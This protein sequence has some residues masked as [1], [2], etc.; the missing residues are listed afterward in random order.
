MSW[1]HTGSSTPL[2]HGEL[3]TRSTFANVPRGSCTKYDPDQ[4]EILD[5]QVEKV[6]ETADQILLRLS[7]I[8]SD[9]C[10]PAAPRI[11]AKTSYRGKSGNHAFQ[12][13]GVDYAGPLKYRKKSGKDG[14]AYIVLCTCS[15]TRVLYLELTSTMETRIPSNFETIN[16]K[17]WETRKNYSDN[18]RTFVGAARWLKTVMADEK[19]QDFLACQ[20]IKW[21]FN[22]S[23]APW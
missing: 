12:V 13:V 21:L 19:M 15:L 23:R 17:T 20:E 9:C 7:Q 4:E 1:S 18:G 2:V 5:T 22:L 14:K 8:P 10:C 16:C 11:A 3:N 6:S